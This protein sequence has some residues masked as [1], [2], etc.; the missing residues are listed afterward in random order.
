LIELRSEEHRLQKQLDVIKKALFEIGCEE[1][2]SGC[3][4]PS[5]DINDIDITVSKLY[6]KIKIL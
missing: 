1:L 4:L 6:L 3:D 2:P 5:L